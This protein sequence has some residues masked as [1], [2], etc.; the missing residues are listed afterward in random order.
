MEKKLFKLF[1]TIFIFI[2]I[3]TEIALSNSSAIPVDAE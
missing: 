2:F 3:N 1:Y